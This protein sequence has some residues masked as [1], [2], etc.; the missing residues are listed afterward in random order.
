M[1]RGSAAICINEKNE[2]LMVAQEKPN[3]PELWSVPSGGVKE[4]ETFEDCCI[5]EVFEEMGYIIKVITKVI[6]RNT[7]TY[8]VDVH[9]KYFE[10][11]IIG[12]GRTF[13]DPDGLILDI[14]WKPI[15]QIN[16]LKLMFEDERE[17][18]LNYIKAKIHY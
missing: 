2:I 15:S 11:E 1:W 10:A 9:I 8:G 18:L 6:E 7:T 4:N 17:I 5:R 13:Q 14:C 16:D 12:G 3:E